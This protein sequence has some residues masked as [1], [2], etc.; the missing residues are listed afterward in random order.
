MTHPAALIQIY[1]MTDPSAL[2][3]VVEVLSDT[4]RFKIDTRTS[5]RGS[6][7]IVEGD[8]PTEALN[9]YEL[10]VVADRETELIYSTAGRLEQSGSGAFVVNDW[11][12]ET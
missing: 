7:L 6:F 12:V 8:D 1:Q 5:D 2:A 10:V 11:V 4:G 9:V 3:S